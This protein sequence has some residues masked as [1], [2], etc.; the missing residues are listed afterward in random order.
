MQEPAAKN[1]NTFFR[2]IGIRGRVRIRDGAVADQAG[3]RER[4]DSVSA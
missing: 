2:K 3:S 4:V 1:R